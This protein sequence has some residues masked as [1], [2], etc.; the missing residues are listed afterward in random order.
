MTLDVAPAGHRRPAV[1]GFYDHRTHSIQYVVSC[2]R[3]RRCAIIDP[4]LDFEEKSGATAT[5]HADVILQYVAENDLAVDWI[6]DTHPHADHFSAAYYL[7]EQTGAPTA[8]GDHIGAVQ[9]IHI[10]GKDEAAYVKLREERDRKLP[11]PKLILSALQVNI[12][13]GLLPEPEDNGKRYLKIPLDA[14]G[15]A[16]WE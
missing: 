8:I 9:N 7:K 11:M 10:A 1:K 16:A 15:G 14:L 6:L 4:V 3:T 13:A 12:R 2:P 5:R